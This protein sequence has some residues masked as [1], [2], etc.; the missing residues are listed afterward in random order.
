M[1]RRERTPADRA[2]HAAETPAEL[3]AYP[4]GVSR[5]QPVPDRYGGFV[6]PLQ[7]QTPAGLLSFFSTT[8]VL[9]TPVDVTLSEL[10]IESFFPA[11][12]ATAQAMR[13]MAEAS[14]RD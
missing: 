1:H 13:A 7:V 14:A 12:D 9:G 4:S 8:T 6:V 11:D 2:R 10:A 3:K 5:T